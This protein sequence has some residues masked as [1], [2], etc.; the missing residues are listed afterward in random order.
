MNWV[1]LGKLIW[2]HSRDMTVFNYSRVMIYQIYTSNGYINL[3]QCKKTG[4]FK[5]ED[6][7]DRL[8]G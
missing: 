3:H 5:I 8:D 6:S 7:R 4:K 2:T 1:S